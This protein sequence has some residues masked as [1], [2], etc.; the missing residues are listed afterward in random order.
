M[1]STRDQAPYRVR[2]CEIR[3]VMNR[4]GITR[5][6]CVCRD[7]RGSERDLSGETLSRI[8]LHSLSPFLYIKSVLTAYFIPEVT[9][10]PS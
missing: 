5:S 9:K 4:I 3:V 2:G 8:S 6:L 1:R 7:Q 10:A